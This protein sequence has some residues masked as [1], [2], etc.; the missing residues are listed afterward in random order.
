[1]VQLQSGKRL[2]VILHQI[3]LSTTITSNGHLKG[4]GM[5]KLLIPKYQ[6]FLPK[7]FHY[8]RLFCF[9]CHYLVFALW[10]FCL[11]R[12]RRISG[13]RDLLKKILATF[14]GCGNFSDLRTMGC[15]NQLSN[16]FVDREICYLISQG[17]AFTR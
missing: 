17:F 10:H 14:N 15:F 13:R 11:A 1:M 7:A 9:F 5:T 3:T 8:K 4:A 2:S 16:I 12:K 6:S